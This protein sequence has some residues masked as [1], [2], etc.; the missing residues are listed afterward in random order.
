MGCM[1]SG[2]GQ[3]I[4]GT[5]AIRN[6]ETGLLLRIKDANSKDGTPLVAY[7]A[8]NWKCMT[9]EFQHVM[10]ETYRLRNLF[11]NKTFAPTDGQQREGTRLEQESLDKNDRSQDWEFIQ[12][13][14]DTYQIRLKGTDLY[15][16]PSDAKGGVN[17][18]IILSPENNSNIQKW[19]IYHQDPQM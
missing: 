13:E 16:T 10:G 19:T 18:P 5:L 14:E 2:Y 7:P 4:K 3:D 12:V 9:W 6:V 17:T 15:L 11:T 8:R 1:L